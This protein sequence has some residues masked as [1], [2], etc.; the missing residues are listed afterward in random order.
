MA[1]IKC[2]DC[3]AEISDNS[4][5]CVKC[6]CKIKGNKEVVGRFIKLLFIAFVLISAI[7]YIFN[8][9]GSSVIEPSINTDSN[10][11]EVPAI[12][13]GEIASIGDWS[14]TQ[15]ENISSGDLVRSALIGSK[16]S[17]SINGDNGKRDRGIAWFRY[18]NNKGIDLNI[19]TKN[20]G[21]RC[22]PCDVIITFD[23]KSSFEYRT[24]NDISTAGNTLKIIDASGIIESIKN[25]KEMKVVIFDDYDKAFIY[26][27]NVDYVDLSGYFDR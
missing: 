5:S 23:S 19:K 9:S 1:L 10:S 20:N 15:V 22:N 13:E 7:S 21:F 8:N 18:Q 26:I 6:G 27:F 11:K 17:I 12:Q 16:N 2:R 3:G 25:S 24:D 4:E 14:F